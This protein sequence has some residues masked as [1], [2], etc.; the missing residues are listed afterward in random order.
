MRQARIAERENA[1]LERQNALL[2]RQEEQRNRIEKQWNRGRQVVNPLDT[3]ADHFMTQIKTQ[4]KVESLGAVTEV[5][6]KKFL[7]Q[8]KAVA[9]DNRICLYPCSESDLKSKQL[10]HLLPWKV[11]PPTINH[12]KFAKALFPRILF[13]SKQSKTYLEDPNIEAFP[14]PQYDA[15]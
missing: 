12:T 8:V 15:S 13:I 9:A 7:R 4:I 5:S 1:Q 14:N 10:V 11:C 3:L 2:K 6:R